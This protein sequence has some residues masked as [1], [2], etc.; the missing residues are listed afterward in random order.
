MNITTNNHRRPYLRTYE[1][2]EDIVMSYDFLPEHMFNG[3]VWTEYQGEFYHNV[4]FD[5]LD[6]ESDA[7]K[8]GWDGYIKSD[9]TSGIVIKS[10][11]LDEYI[12]GTYQQ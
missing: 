3:A 7:F 1:V 10:M 8:A 2:P 5:T 11:S 6:P 9:D 4:A 12:I